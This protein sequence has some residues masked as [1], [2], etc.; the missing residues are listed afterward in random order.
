ME[1]TE[2]EGGPERRLALLTKAMELA[3]AA[4]PNAPN[5]GLI[6]TCEFVEGSGSEE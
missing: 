2:E 3:L 4:L 5:M 1:W 6:I